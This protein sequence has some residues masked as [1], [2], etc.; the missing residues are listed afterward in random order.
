MQ[1]R[2]V[3]GLWI[4][5]TGC[6]S[7]KS[8]HWI[9]MFLSRSSVLGL[10]TFQ[11]ANI[12]LRTSLIVQVCGY[13]TGFSLTSKGRNT[14]LPCLHSPHQPT[15][16]L[17]STIFKNQVK[18]LCLGMRTKEKLTAQHTETRTA[19]NWNFRKKLHQDCECL[20]FEQQFFS[21]AL[22]MLFPLSAALFT[23]GRGLIWLWMS[24]SSWITYNY[25][26]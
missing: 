18:Q 23:S 22:G 7:L 21:L 20:S 24:S 1:I 12:K 3:S 17:Q 9:I 14:T 13:G 26:S 6:K 4:W 2:E 11:W 16:L 19:K 8:K 5:T 25:F 15:I 10:W